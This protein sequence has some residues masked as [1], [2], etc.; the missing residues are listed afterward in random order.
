LGERRSRLRDLR[1]EATSRINE[2]LG[3]GIRC[4]V[5]EEGNKSEY[6]TTLM[7]L[8]EG[9][10]IKNREEE[11][12]KIVD[13][14]SPDELAGYLLKSDIASLVVKTKVKA[15]TA[16]QLGSVVS[17][18][19]KLNLQTLRAKPV[20]RITFRRAGESRLTDLKKLSLGE[21][22]SAILSIILLD[23]GRPLLID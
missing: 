9:S 13:A 21:K 18:K 6:L 19:D 17:L 20:L 10:K 14:L 15:N 2:E 22:C 23:R 3:G 11:L 12:E 7:E 1:K 8:A 16:E 4:E 5:I